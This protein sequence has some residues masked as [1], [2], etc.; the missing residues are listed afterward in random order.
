MYS[1]KFKK[2]F[3]NGRFNPDK[4]KYSM[5]RMFDYTVTDTNGNYAWKVEN[6]KKSTLETVK[7]VMDKN[8]PL[9]TKRSFTQKGAFSK[10]TLTDA[11]TAKQENY[12]PVKTQDARF[13][14]NVK[15]YGGYAK[16]NGSHFF[17]VE[18]SAKGKRQKSFEFLPIY[19]AQTIKTREQ[20]E[21]YCKNVLSLVQPKV[22]IEK[23][24][25]Y[26]RFKINGFFYYLTGRTDQRLALT[27]ATELK[28]DHDSMCT[29]QKVEQSEENGFEFF[30]ESVTKE[31]LQAVYEQLLVK[32]R[33]GIFSKK[34]NPMGATLEANVDKFKQLSLQKQAKLIIQLLKL[35]ATDEKSEAKLDILDLGVCGTARI[36]KTVRSDKYSEFILI[37][38]SPTGLYENR[39]DLLGL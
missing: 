27:N 23:I 25:M 5:A 16:V 38:Q 10:K 9:V 6:G 24:E 30:D 37:H 26:S 29:I 8:T 34:I 17:L 39:I 31:K 15:T 13:A 12:F 35:S 18:H 4:I 28:L 11:K 14:R 3:R 19:L 36:S 22:L 1:T 20:I 21:A 7:K 32:H 33:D 2:Y